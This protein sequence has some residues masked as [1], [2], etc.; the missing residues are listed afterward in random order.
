MK[1]I[2]GRFESFNQGSNNDVFENDDSNEK[3]FGKYI[4]IK[5][6]GNFFFNIKRIWRRRNSIFSKIRNRRI[7]IK[8]NTYEKTK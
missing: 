7:C 5:K 4:Y 2:F 1:K 3:K 6:L 8:E